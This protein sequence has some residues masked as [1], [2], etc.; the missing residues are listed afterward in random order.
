[1]A[2]NAKSAGNNENRTIQK[3][4]DPGNYPARVVQIL[5][6]GLQPQRA[7][8]GEAKAPMQEIGLTYELVD[9]FMKDEE[10]NDI[11]D[12]PRWI[13][14]QIPL[15]NLRADLAKST[16]RYNALDPNG[17]H[18]G[19]FSALVDTPC[20]VT[21]VNNA[22]GDK[23]YDNIA[24]VGAMRAKD[25]AACPPLVNP[26][27]VFDLDAPDMEV[28]G[29][30]P[31]WLQEKI[32][33]NLNYQGSP[34]QKLIGGEAPPKV[35]KEKPKAAPKKDRGVPAADDDNDPPF[36]GGKVVDDNNPY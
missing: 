31:K 32:Q 29:K 33:G 27:A 3:N 16:K 22:S 30:L 17:V 10:G 23:I 7:F 21:I 28:F 15:H 18:E 9:E 20:L 13:S 36:D 25:A 35:E 34:L 4:L 26:V 24:A 6:L 1:M 14:E 11:A 12:K 8:K 2:L 5:D 19:D